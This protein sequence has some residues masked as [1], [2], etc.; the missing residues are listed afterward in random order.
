[1]KTSTQRG[2]YNPLDRPVDYQVMLERKG[3][4]VEHKVMLGR[5]GLTS[6]AGGGEKRVNK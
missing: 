1:M 2:W 4:I 3:L 5:K 6:N